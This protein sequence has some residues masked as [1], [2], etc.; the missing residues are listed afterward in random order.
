MSSQKSYITIDF[1]NMTTTTKLIDLSSMVPPFERLK[2]LKRNKFQR[3]LSSK[4]FIPCL[5]IL[6]TIFVT[7]L[8]V[9]G[10]SQASSYQAEEVSFKTGVSM[11]DDIVSPILN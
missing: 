10:Q 6:L 3:I 4:T 5:S 8:Q 2:C 7:S 11:T 9:N 1:D